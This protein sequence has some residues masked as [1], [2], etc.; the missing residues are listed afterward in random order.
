MIIATMIN[1]NKEP[2]FSSAQ[3]FSGVVACQTLRVRKGFIGRGCSFIGY[4][5]D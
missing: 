2:G 1:T 4:P 3:L 5:Q